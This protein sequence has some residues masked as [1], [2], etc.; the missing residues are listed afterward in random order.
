MKGIGIDNTIE[1]NRKLAFKWFTLAAEQGNALA[2]HFLGM[3]YEL[4][5]GIELDKNE[6]DKWYALAI[7]AGYV[8]KK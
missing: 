5:D 7:T 1:A 3:C 2:Q 4:G 8:E 6:A